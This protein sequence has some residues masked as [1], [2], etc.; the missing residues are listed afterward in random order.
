[1]LPIYSISTGNSRG[2]VVNCSRVFPYAVSY[3]AYQNVQMLP[4]ELQEPAGSFL[5]VLRHCRP[6]S[7]TLRGEE[8]YDLL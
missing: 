2:V 3:Q 8:L 5:T 4:R 7:L 1:M 6:D